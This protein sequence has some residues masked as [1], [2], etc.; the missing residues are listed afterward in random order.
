[1]DRT[2]IAVELRRIAGRA[3]KLTPQD[4]VNEARDPA[5]PLHAHF[6]W[7]D[8]AAAASW[9]IE[10]ARTL[11]RSVR[12]E[13]TTE[14]KMVST[15]YYVRDPEKGADEQGYVALP[16]LKRQ[17]DLAREA[18]VAEFARAGAAMKR[19]R[20]LADALEMVGEIEEIATRIEALH[21]E[22]QSDAA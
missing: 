12:V 3:G 21:D 16:K 7:D 20:D 4:V 2:A 18:L 15:V 11:I 22:A 14:T 5:N 10:Q 8:T 6:E 13:I 9:R 19:A 17:P 1:M